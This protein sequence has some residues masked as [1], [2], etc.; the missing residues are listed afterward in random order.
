MRTTMVNSSRLLMPVEMANRSRSTRL[1]LSAARQCHTKSLLPTSDASGQC[2]YVD[3]Q[4]VEVLTDTLIPCCREDSS[5]Y[6]VPAYG[7]SNLR[8]ELWISLVEKAYAKAVGSYESILK[9]KPHEVLLHLTGGSIQQV[10]S[11][12]SKNYLS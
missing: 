3:G 10:S 6:L 8:D 4:W 1:R 12:Q 5:G 9:I 2:F 7:R 11:V